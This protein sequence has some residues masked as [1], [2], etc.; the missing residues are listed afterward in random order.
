[1]INSESHESSIHQNLPLL[2]TPQKRFAWNQTITCFEKENHL[3]QSSL[4]VGFHVNFQGVLG[5]SEPTP[6]AMASLHAAKMTSVQRVAMATPQRLAKL[7]KPVGFFNVKVSDKKP[8]ITTF[9]TK[10]RHR[11]DIWDA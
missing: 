9:L 4:T 6:K 10:Q 2:Y 1:V 5:G 7:I 8:Q 3:N 11:K